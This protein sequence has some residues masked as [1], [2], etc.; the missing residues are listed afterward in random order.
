MLD[1]DMMN[2]LLSLDAESFV[3]EAYQIIL[4]RK[5]DETGCQ[6]HVAA[7]NRGVT[8][9]RLLFELRI[10]E[11]GM[12]K[13]VRLKDFDIHAIELDRLILL[14]G[15][16]FLDAAYI[17]ILGRTPDPEGKKTIL[18]GLS[19]KSL[20]KLE[21]IYALRSSE[22]GKKH[23]INVLGLSSAYRRWKIRNGI[24]KLPVIGGAIHY[25]WDLIHFR[26]RIAEQ[27]GISESLAVGHVHEL[28]A[29]EE[30][31]IHELSIRLAEAEAKVNTLHNEMQIADILRQKEKVL[32]L[33]QTYK[34]YEDVMRGDRETILRR[35]N[36][37]ESVINRVKENNGD[38]LYALDLGCGRGEWL[39]LLKT[40]YGIDSLGIDSDESM[41][42]DAV[43]YGLNCVHADLLKFIK[44]AESCSYDII[45]MFQV[46]EHLPFNV[47]SDTI[48]ECVRVLRSGGALIIETPNPEN[49]IIGSCNFYFDPTHVTKLPPALLEILVKGA[50]LNNTEVA[51]MHPYSAVNTEGL[52]EGEKEQEVL[53]GFA[54][55]FNNFADYA[56]IAYKQI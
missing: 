16:N 26:S 23:G 41:M 44:N 14:E 6:N 3:R 45:T 32:S 28:Q 15:S 7:L 2:K 30:K 10:S 55:F 36:I 22:E 53:R 52:E 38:G 1:K 13:G 11:E 20:N 48:K 46:A 34:A 27:A 35:L 17:A 39:E 24:L 42:E 25:L 51:R 33:G 9:E 50:G 49:M 18:Q 43:H 8:K 29:E 47:L 19:S 4:L 54:A 31:K 21:V 12:K 37:Y 40:T 5:F 56:V